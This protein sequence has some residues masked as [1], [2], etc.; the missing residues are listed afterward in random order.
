MGKVT[1]ETHHNMNKVDS[2]E[3]DNLASVEVYGSTGMGQY[4]L[5][6]NDAKVV[7]RLNGQFDPESGNPL[8]VEDGEVDAVIEE[9]PAKATVKK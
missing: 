3:F 8:K 5:G 9:A 2:Q 6:P 7:V 1:V 4:V